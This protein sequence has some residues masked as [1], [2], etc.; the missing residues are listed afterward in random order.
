MSKADSF[1]LC[2]GILLLACACSAKVVSE[3]GKA[4]QAGDTLSLPA[5]NLVGTVTLE[6]AI[7]ARRSVRSFVS[8]DLSLPEISQLLWAGQ[9]LTETIPWKK[10]AAPSAGA[11]Y[12]LELYVLWR[13]R[14]WHY[15][16]ELHA[17]VLKSGKMNQGQLADAA[18]GQQ[19]IRGAPACF[20]VSGVY[21]RT[22]AKYGKRAQR[23]VHIEVGHAAQNILLQAVALGLGG[24]TI[25]AFQDGEVKKLLSL[26]KEES[27]LYIVP[28]GKK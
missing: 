21:S 28:V 8:E 3:A 24:V 2:F 26:E 17:V 15:L 13:N 23:Y 20:I 7:S 19:A 4:D 14:L 27:P 11:L 5:P 16:P 1:V 6:E 18:L 9:G 12:P 10:R 22:A 25:G